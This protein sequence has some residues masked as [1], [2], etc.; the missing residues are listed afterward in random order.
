LPLIGTRGPQ[1]LEGLTNKPEAM[2]EGLP[3]YGIPGFAS[4]TCVGVALG[5]GGW[6]L[7]FQ[8]PPAWGEFVSIPGASRAIATY[9]F[10]AQ[11]TYRNPWRN[12]FKL[13][14]IT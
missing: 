9:V 2:F 5:E 3:V 12:S 7:T 13:T 8:S 10:R 6:G 11:A 4:G 14:G 1:G